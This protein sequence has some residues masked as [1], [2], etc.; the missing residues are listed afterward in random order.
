MAGHGGD[1]SS[2]RS[3]GGGLVLLVVVRRRGS[4]RR[5]LVS[6]HELRKFLRITE[7]GQ[8]FN[9]RDDVDNHTANQRSVRG[10]QHA[11]AHI[12]ISAAA[13]TDCSCLIV[14]FYR[15]HV[16]AHCKQLVNCGI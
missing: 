8:P 5:K 12:R 14:V 10:W 7:P 4:A 11:V 6:V 3:A 13:R 16:I 15:L 2:L 1:E 9:P